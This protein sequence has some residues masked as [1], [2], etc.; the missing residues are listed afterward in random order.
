MR[1][2]TEIVKLLLSYKANPN[3]INEIDD[4][5]IDFA[6]CRG[7]KDI[8]ELL[9]ENDAYP[10]IRCN[11]Y[12]NTPLMDACLCKRN[13]IIKLLLENGAD[14]KLT[15]GDDETALEIARKQKNKEAVKIILKYM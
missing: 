7:N 9:L 10:D 8:V 2:Y 3:V 15:N 5:P 13:E 11:Q 4:T 6:V 14:P 1:N 12:V